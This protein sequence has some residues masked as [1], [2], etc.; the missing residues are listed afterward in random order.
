MLRTNSRRS[1]I[2]SN[3]A[4]RRFE[5]KRKRTRDNESAARL[6]SHAAG[7]DRAADD[8]GSSKCCVQIPIS[9]ITHEDSRGDD[10]LSV[11]L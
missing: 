4:I 8:S 6:Q 7:N 1:E 3:D 2:A 10:D 5:A 11:G 9:L